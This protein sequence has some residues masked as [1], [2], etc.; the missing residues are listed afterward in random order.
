MG[1]PRIHD[2]ETRQ[3]LLRAAEAMVAHGGV[4]ALSVR[5]LAVVGQTTTRAIYSLFGGKEGVIRALHQRSWT[6]LRNRLASVPTSDDPVEDLVR[7]G[8]DGFRWFA[9][10]H[11]NLF[12]LTFERSP[13]W[14]MPDVLAES[15]A[16]RALLERRVERCA[17]SGRLGNAPVGLVSW[18]FHALTLGLASAELNG[19]LGRFDDLVPVWETALRSFIW[20]V[21]GG[22]Y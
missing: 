11:P 19:W 9:V 15:V 13:P 5:N 12:R 1:R 18:Q 22:A 6:L 16:A 10:N 14:T 21:P 4:E 8:I 2:D 7:L 17:R 3:L 20:G